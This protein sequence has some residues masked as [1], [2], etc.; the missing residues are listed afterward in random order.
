MCLVVVLSMCLLYVSLGSRF[1]P[2]SLGSRVTLGILGLMFIGSMVL[3]VRN[4]VLYS[5]RSV[6]KRVHAVLSGLRMRLFVRV[7]A[8]YAAN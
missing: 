3:V 1:S 5:A 7:H 8:Y 2:S 4:Y 6:V